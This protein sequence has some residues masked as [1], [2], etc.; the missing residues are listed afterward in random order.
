[1][2]APAAAPATVEPAVLAP[3]VTGIGVA[4]PG[5]DD[6][7]RLLA[8][9][10]ADPAADGSWFD[11]RARLGGRGYKYLP[12]ACHYLL[13]AARQALADAGGCLDRHLPT[14]RALAVGTT[15][16]VAAL[17]AEMDS[18]VVASSADALSPALAPFFSVNLVAGRVSME[19]AIKAFNLTLNTPAVGGLEAL[20]AGS[21]AV[22]AGRA[23]LLLAG[24]TEPAA[25]RSAGPGA[26]G[27]GAG[28]A[29]G[30]APV[31]AVVLVVEPA[32]PAG[33][34]GYGS[35]VTRTL[36]LPP[37]LLA[38]PAGWRAAVA[39]VQAEVERLV[40]PAAV[41]GCH[42][43]TAGSPVGAAVTAALGRAGLPATQA[44]AGTVAGGGCL[45]PVLRVAGRLAAGGPA[46]LVVATSAQGHVGLTLVR[47]AAGRDRR[48]G[49]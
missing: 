23:T 49:C 33:V 9:G 7:A 34:V 36:F 4:C 43:F 15:G 10:V 30:G 20:Q 5:T 6:P 27:T 42:A 11:V 40:G 12:P 46:E 39:R 25:A 45:A 32:P 21:R 13:A 26:A 35:C 38:T 29:A 24:A 37:R 44:P 1:V 2:T 8:A 16:A 18:T 31:G 41:A 17:H 47:C 14:G 48:P 22:A 19:H 28:A 3:M